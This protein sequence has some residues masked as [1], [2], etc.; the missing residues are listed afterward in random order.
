V[1][2]LAFCTSVLPPRG[3]RLLPDIFSALVF[4]GLQAECGEERLQDVEAGFGAGGVEFSVHAVGRS[5][6]AR[7]QRG[8]SVV[9][10]GI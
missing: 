6:R 10:S 7:E 8:S 2:A 9:V 3:A 4:D 5:R 1:S